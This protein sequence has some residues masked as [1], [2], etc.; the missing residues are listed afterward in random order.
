MIWI[1]IGFLVAIALLAFFINPAHTGPK[2][3]VGIGAFFAAIAS[4]YIVTRQLP[5]SDTFG[6]TELVTFVSLMTILLTLLTSAISVWVY[7]QL[8]E[9]TLSRRLDRLA[10]VIIGAGYVTLNL[11]AALAA[12]V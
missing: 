9:A 5:L 12:S 8:G 3:E 6:L 10:Q 4:T 11:V 1:L 2:F 7:G